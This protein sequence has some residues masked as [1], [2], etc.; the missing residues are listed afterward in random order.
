M[1]LVVLCGRITKDAEVRY[2]GENPV[3]RFTLAVDRKF[4]KDQQSA[5][6]ISCVCFGK[7][8]EFMEKYGNKGTKFIVT[9]E[10]RSGSY[11]NKDN[12]TVYTTDVVVNDI[13]FAESKSN[14]QQAAPAPS[15]P[16]VDANGFMQ[17]QDDAQEELP[18]A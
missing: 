14:N 6:F 11:K 3:G 13:E 4:N 9:G 2:N 15:K 18:F 8:A 5:D 7:K 12:Q 16:T 1:N 17:I 10:I